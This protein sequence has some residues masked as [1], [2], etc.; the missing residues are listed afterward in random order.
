[1]LDE[2]YLILS[3]IHSAKG[4]EWKSVFVLNVVDGCLPSDL[5]AGTTAEIEEERR[6]LYV[7]MTPA[8]DDLHLIVPQRFFTHGQSAQGDRHV[9]AS[10]T[11]FI[12]DGLLG[13]FEMTSWP[14]LAV[15]TQARVVGQGVRLNVGGRVRGMWR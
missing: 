8:K 3:T 13:L 1:L 14:P 5:G 4:Q 2:D 15:G 7:A 6:L 11:R 9:Y 12:P 10:R